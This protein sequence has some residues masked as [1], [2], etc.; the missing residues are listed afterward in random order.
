MKPIPRYGVKWQNMY[1]PI[2]YCV[3]N[4]FPFQNRTMMIN[5]RLGKV[6][7][8]PQSDQGFLYLFY[9]GD[10]RYV[11][12]NSHDIDSDII[13]LLWERWWWSF[14]MCQIMWF[15]QRV[16]IRVKV[17]SV[18]NTYITVPINFDCSSLQIWYIMVTT[19]HVFQ[20]WKYMVSPSYILFLS[21]K[22]PRYIMTTPSVTFD[23]FI[24][25]SFKL[26]G[27]VKH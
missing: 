22:I 9:I 6:D 17:L 5:V 18:G 4:I 11:D 13:L 2:W 16:I 8:F 10:E 23:A 1:H 14:I 12:R 15:L 26:C 19:F 20:G 27:E 21:R 25:Q 7:Q 3:G 24:D